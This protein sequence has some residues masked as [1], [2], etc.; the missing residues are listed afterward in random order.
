MY[1]C[2]VQSNLPFFSGYAHI[3]SA[4]EATDVFFNPDIPQAKQLMDRFYLYKHL[5]FFF[6]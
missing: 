6:N 3:A 5:Y 1:V 4:F 2:L